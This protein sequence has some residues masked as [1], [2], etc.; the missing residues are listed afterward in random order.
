MIPSVRK[1]EKVSQLIAFARDRRDLL[2]SLFHNSFLKLIA[3][4]LDLRCE[5]LAHPGCC[6]P[7]VKD[8]IRPYRPLG[9]T[10]VWQLDGAHASGYECGV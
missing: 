6:V 8:L 5:V 1:K 10:Y 4:I 2:L 9:V 7:L 3:I